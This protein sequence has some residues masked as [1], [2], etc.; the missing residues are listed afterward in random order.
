MSKPDFY[1]LNY[2]IPVPEKLNTNLFL[3]KK[4]NLKFITPLSKVN[5]FTGANNSGKSLIAREL[6]KDIESLDYPNPEVIELINLQVDI[7][8]DKINDYL[9]SLYTK[10]IELSNGTNLRYDGITNEIKYYTGLIKISQYQ[11]KLSNYFSNAI[12]NPRH[13]NHVI[14]SFR[15]GFNQ[16]QQEQYKNFLSQVNKT[17]QE[18]LT[19]ILDHKGYSVIYVPTMRSLRKY[20]TVSFLLDK[21]QQEYQFPKT[22]NIENGQN[23]YEGFKKMILS[24]YSDRKRKEEFENFLSEYFFE[25]KLVQINPI[26][27]F[28]EISISIGNEKEK[29]IYELGDGLQMI[30]ILTFL[31]FVYEKGIIMIEE[32]EIFM[33]PGLQKK[34]MDIIINHKRSQ[35][36]QFLIVSHSN[37]IIDAANISDKVSIFGVTKFLAKQD[38]VEP[39]FIVRNLNHEEESAL[40]LLGVSNSSVYLSNCTIWVE[41]ISDMLY[42]SKFLEQYLKQEN[43][44]AKYANCSKFQEGIHYSFVL[45]G[46][47]NIIHYDFSDTLIIDELSKKVIVKNLCGRAMVIVDDDDNK[48]V[49]RKEKFFTELGGRFKVLKVIEIENLL[50]NE[51]ISSTV[52][53]FSSWKKETFE[54]KNYLPESKMAKIRLG[55]YIDNYITKGIS[56]TG[57]KKFSIKKTT[58]SASVTI[59]CKTDFASKA[60]K[61]IS[62]KNMSKASLK[63]VEEVLDFIISNNK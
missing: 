29:P 13:Y 10:E 12:V 47:D 11:H 7:C 61:H 23:L 40:N 56:K 45:T 24:Y 46:G 3:D 41:G 42:I 37:H 36:F 31:L 43:I 27:D 2:K 62:H 48:N 18:N 57:K 4:T 26:Q 6:I 35:E 32:P 58:K 39:N 9:N 28:Q 53:E 60:L 20:E 5:I 1:K 21:T 14:H 50:S 63:L 54:S 15:S 44:P 34:F 8:Q 59:N 16:S 33:H 17:L 52:K 38:E 25:E 49:A 55:T 51:T 19:E 22:I 30:V